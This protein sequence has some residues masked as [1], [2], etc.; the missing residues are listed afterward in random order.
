MTP[1][2]KLTLQR[3]SKVRSLRNPRHVFTYEGSRFSE[4]RGRLKLR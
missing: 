1:D 4:S 2:V 3:L